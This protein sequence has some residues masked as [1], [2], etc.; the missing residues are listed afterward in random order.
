MKRYVRS[1]QYQKKADRHMQYIAFIS[2]KL[3]QIA[4]T[5][6]EEEMKELARDL[7]L[8]FATENSKADLMVWIV[9]ELEWYIKEFNEQRAKSNKFPKVKE[10]LITYIDSTLGYDLYKTEG[11]W[12]EDTYRIEHSDGSEPTLKEMN[13]ICRA[14]I[15]PFD[16]KFDEGLDGSWTSHSGHIRGVDFRIGFE[17]DYD[18]D[19]QGKED[20]LQLQF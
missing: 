9:E 16:A 10:D 8:K 3:A 11:E 7:G 19:P 18:L 13:D 20:S 5:D 1:N 17:R 4:K 6:S 12:S 2:E 14:L 15:E